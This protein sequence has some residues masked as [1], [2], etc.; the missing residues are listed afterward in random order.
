MNEIQ[1]SI[2]ESMNA[3]D[4]IDVMNLNDGFLAS[5]KEWSE[6][7]QEF[8]LEVARTR[9]SNDD[10]KDQEHSDPEEEEDF[11]FG[12]S[13]DAEIKGG[14]KSASARLRELNELRNEGEIT[15][16]E[17]DAKRKQ[18]INEI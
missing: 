12:E 8:C 11:Y 17:Y 2:K 15:L 9:I 3:K 4:L 16:E 6:D 14:I 13:N 10:D 18:I 1:N 7:L 5:L